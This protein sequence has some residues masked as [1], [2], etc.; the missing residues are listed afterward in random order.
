M[1]L[2]KA[3]PKTSPENPKVLSLNSCSYFQG[4]AVAFL[5]KTVIIQRKRKRIKVLEQKI[6]QIK[7]RSQRSNMFLRY[8][9]RR[10]TVSNAQFW[11]AGNQTSQPQLNSLLICQL[12]YMLNC[13][14]GSSC[15]I[16]TLVTLPKPSLKGQPK[17][18]KI[19][20]LPCPN[21]SS[22]HALSYSNVHEKL[23]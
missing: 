16:H 10:S 22:P 19:D 6:S 2:S 3:V 8:L 4:Y 1:P 9:K 11:R 13:F 5:R 12:P 14:K 17:K 18:N 21:T 7:H 20:F 15:M 23:P